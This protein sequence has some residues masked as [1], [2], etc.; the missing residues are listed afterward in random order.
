LSS[1]R[2]IDRIGELLWRRHVLVRN[3]GCKSRLI[4]GWRRSTRTF[5]GVERLLPLVT[6]IEL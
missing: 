5:E 3:V 6:G 1:S 4:S 2:G